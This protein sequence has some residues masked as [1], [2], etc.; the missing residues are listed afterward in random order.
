[1]RA[2]GLDATVK[3]FIWW[4]NFKVGN[5]DNPRDRYQAAAFIARLKLEMDADSALGYPIDLYGSDSRTGYVKL[6]EEPKL[7]GIYV[8]ADKRPMFNFMTM[9]QGV[10]S[11]AELR[12][13]KPVKFD[14]LF[15][16]AKAVLPYPRKQ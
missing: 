10:K 7:Y 5:L 14:E 15:Q 9:M 4:R 3:D 13:S 12:R 1:M 6:V 2:Y 11:E 16:K 8:E